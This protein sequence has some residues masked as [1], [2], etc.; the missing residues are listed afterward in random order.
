MLLAGCSWQV[1][2]GPS[3]ATMQPTTGQE[4]LDL[5]KARDAGAISAADYEVQKAR[6][7]GGK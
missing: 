4:L 2:T 3:H 7:L 5:Q 6:V 1:G